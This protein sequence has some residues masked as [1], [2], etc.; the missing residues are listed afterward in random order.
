[1]QGIETGFKNLCRKVYNLFLSGVMN[2]L[3]D[4][5]GW[6][7]Q[8]FLDLYPFGFGLMK[9]LCIKKIL[10]EKNNISYFNYLN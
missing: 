1:M 4:N 5:I 8:I 9:H 10:Y 7:K 3:D 6:I 2:F